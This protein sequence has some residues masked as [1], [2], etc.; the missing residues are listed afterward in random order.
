L[1]TVQLR[2]GRVGMRKVSETDDCQYD[3]FL[4]R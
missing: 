2:V 1:V 4:F 3:H